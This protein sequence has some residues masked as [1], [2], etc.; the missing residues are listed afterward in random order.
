MFCTGG[1]RCE[2]ASSLLI[3]RG[4][5][6]VF[7]LKGGILKYLER[8]ES[9]KSKWEGECF[10]FDQRVSVDHDLAPGVHSL[11]FGCQEPISP[12]EMK[13]SRYEEGVCCG[14]CH[15]K[16][17]EDLKTRRRERMKQVALA[18]ERGERHIGS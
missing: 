15:D 5:E 14:R 3:E 18:T 2:K 11:C 4:F 16:T 17:T 12:E 9:D 1:I 10:V 8:V 7:H 13:D 6:E